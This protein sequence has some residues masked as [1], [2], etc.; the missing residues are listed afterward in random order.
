VSLT[1]ANR[2]GQGAEIFVDLD[3]NFVDN[4]AQ[5]SANGSAVAQCPTSG[6]AAGTCVRPPQ[7]VPGGPGSCG[8]LWFF[9]LHA[10][11]LNTTASPNQY[12]FAAQQGSCANAK[13]SMDVAADRQLQN[14]CS[15]GDS[16]ALTDPDL[17]TIT[18]SASPST[19]ANSFGTGTDRVVNVHYEGGPPCP[20]NCAAPPAPSSG[21]VLPFTGGRGQHHAL[22]PARI[23]DTRDGTGA[24]SMSSLAV[25]N[26]LDRMSAANLGPGGT[27]DVQ[28]AGRGGVPAS[29]VAAV[30]MNV[31]VTNTTGSGYLVVYPKGVARPIASNVNWTAG[32]TVPNLVEVPLGADGKVTVYNSAGA[33]D[34]VFDVAGYV[35]TSDQS[36]GSSGLYNARVPSRLLDTRTGLGGATTVGAGGTVSLQVTGRGGVPATGVSAVVLNV[37]A[38]GATASSY[39]TVWPDGA[40]RP[41]ASN[42]NFV[43][44]Q[45]VPNRVMVPVGTG[46]K[47]DL[48]NFAGN[49]DLVVDVGGYFTDASSGG[50]GSALAPLAPARILDTRDGTGGVSSPL[51]SGVVLA[52]QVAGL[53][54]VPPMQAGTPP[55]AVV[56]NV[57]VTNPTASSYLTLWPDGNLPPLASD[58]NYRRGQTVANLVVV[59]VG[60]DGKVRLFNPAGS[61]D[62]VIDIVGWYG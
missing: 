14:C 40:A 43:A 21:P 50:T 47:V 4:S 37:T 27:M 9:H 18:F 19:P 41:L 56:L 38:T 11:Q 52:V 20:P 59:Q 57:T 46:G 15:P 32:Q 2:Y 23:L 30:I 53:K 7:F 51:A 62:V 17:G 22:P 42:L 60:A 45:T 12:V 34:V 36:V 28:I 26:A 29:G 48:Y 55:K 16:A 1:D 44:G 33:T 24:V 39:V 31:T 54:G 25:R 35:S 58:L 3:G 5:V 6:P 49:V 61:V 10:A 13:P 8:G